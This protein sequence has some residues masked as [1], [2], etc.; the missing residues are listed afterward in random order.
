MQL[1]VALDGAAD[2]PRPVANTVFLR[3]AGVAHR[4]VA[5]HAKARNAAPGLPERDGMLQLEVE[6]DG[7]GIDARALEHTRSLGIK[8]M[9]E[10]VLYMGGALEISRAPRGGT[11]VLARVPRCLP[12]RR[13]GDPGAARR[14][15][16]PRAP[17]AAPVARSERRHPRRGRSGERR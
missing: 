16:A 11:R 2:V 12:Q 6:D 15:P 17:G 5:R 10:R 1:E 4:N 13:P 14:R 7:R 3:A 9:R 8:G